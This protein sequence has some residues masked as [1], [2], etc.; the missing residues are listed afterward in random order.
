MVTGW[1]RYIARQL[2]SLIKNVSISF[3]G[4][5][6]NILLNIL[7]YLQIASTYTYI[8]NGHPKLKSIF[9]FSSHRQTM[10]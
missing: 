4:D 3:D 10:F 7:M 1:T 8:Y 2:K 6:E 9:E 5:E